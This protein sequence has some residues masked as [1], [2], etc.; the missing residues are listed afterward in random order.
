MSD[1]NDAPRLYVKGH[2]LIE[3][4]TDPSNV[5]TILDKSNAIHPENMSFSIANSLAALTDTQA[6]SIGA[7]SEM[8]FGKTIAL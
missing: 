1:Y 2:V 7:I 5:T 3:D 8:R 4:I 6:K